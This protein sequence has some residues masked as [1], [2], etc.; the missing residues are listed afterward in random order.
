MVHVGLEA[1]GSADAGVCAVTVL[2]TLYQ[3]VRRAETP[4][5]LKLIMT[6]AAIEIEN[7]Q[8]EVEQLRAEV[9]ELRDAWRDHAEYSD[10]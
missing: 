8:A 1:S 9:A 2:N 3:E 6:G 10:R 4:D 5:M 7:L